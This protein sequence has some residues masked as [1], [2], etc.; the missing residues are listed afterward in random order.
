[1]PIALNMQLNG[2]TVGKDTIYSMP[3]IK[4]FQTMI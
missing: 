1:M 2:L 3:G 4:K